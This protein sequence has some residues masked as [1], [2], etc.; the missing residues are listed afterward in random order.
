LGQEV[1]GMSDGTPSDAARLSDG[2]LVVA[3]TRGSQAALREVYGRHGA[4]VFATARRLCGGVRAEEVV[5]DI[6]VALWHRP[7]RYDPVRAT[8]RGFLTMQARR[9][10]ID[11]LS[12]DGPRIEHAPAPSTGL[13]GPGHEGDGLDHALAQLPAT[14]REAIV[15]AFFGGQSYAEVAALL[16][17]PE[18]TVRYRIRTGLT[19][20]R[21]LLADPQPDLTSPI[22]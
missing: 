22:P 1:I 15:L 19:R 6:F 12:G 16:D 2:G 7:D 14:Q 17:Q 18:G 20:L 5:K 10:A 13:D 11:Q 4:A 8:L 9:R 3:I 21:L